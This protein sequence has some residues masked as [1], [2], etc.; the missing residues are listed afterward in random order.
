MTNR[1]FVAMAF[2]LTWATIAS[3]LVHLRNFR[4]RAQTRFDSA[5]AGGVR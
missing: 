1:I 2:V 5:H 4:R 3:Y